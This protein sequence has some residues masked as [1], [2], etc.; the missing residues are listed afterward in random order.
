M[1]TV[2]KVYSPDEQQQL[3]QEIF[4]I[5]DSQTAEDIFYSIKSRYKI[6]YIV[7]A[8]EDR[9][10]KFFRKF[11]ISEHYSGLIWDCSRG[12]I[13]IHSEE[14]VTT[15]EHQLR[16]TFRIKD[17]CFEQD[18]EIV[19]TN[20]DT[21]YCEPVAVFKTYMN[22]SLNVVRNLA[23]YYL[24]MPE[25]YKYITTDVPHIEMYFP[26]LNYQKRYSKLVKISYDIYKK[27]L[28]EYNLKELE[29]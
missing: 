5:G 7:S 10:I 18:I 12:L 15:A 25:G 24:T 26:I 14:E 29:V 27:M 1:A 9:V 20:I 21:A 8:E 16:T 19:G 3:R 13:D 4:D 11:C 6:L 2:K 28:N 23:V 22:R 17:S